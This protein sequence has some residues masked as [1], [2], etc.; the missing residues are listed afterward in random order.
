MIIKGVCECLGMC[1]S[2]AGE[3]GY[4]ALEASS[5]EF[6]QPLDQI[7]AGDER[8]VFVISGLAAAPVRCCVH[9]L[10]IGAVGGV[11]ARFGLLV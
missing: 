7:G 2:A 3:V 6:F 10:L 9:F 8:G 1:V 4:H 5:S 11:H